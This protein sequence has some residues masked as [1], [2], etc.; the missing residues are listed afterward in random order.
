[1]SSIKQ[2]TFASRI[3][4]SVFIISLISACGGGGGNDGENTPPPANVAPTANA[5]ADQTVDEETTVILSGNGTDSD[6]S[7]TSYAWAQTTGTSVTINGA[8]TATASFDTPTTTTHLTLT[9]QL[10]ITDNDGATASDTID[11]VVNPVNIIPTAD[12]GTDQTV[13]EMTNVTLSG[14]GTDTDGLIDTYMW[15]QSVGTPVTLTNGNTQ[16]AY[17]TAPNVSS[18]E[19]L[20]FELLVTDNEGAEATDTIDITVNPN[21]PPTASAG[22]AQFVT[23][24]NEVTL[25]ASASTDVESSVTYSWLQTD[26]TGINITLDDVNAEQPSF[27]A[28]SLTAAETITFEV[29]VTDAGSLFDT[30]TVN[31]AIAPVITKKINDTGITLCGDLGGSGNYSNSENCSDSIDAEGDVIPLGQDGHYGRDVSANDNGDGN[32][33]FSFTKL[34]ENGEPLPQS[35]SNWSCVKD[36]VTGLIWEVKSND[37]GLQDS[38]NTYT[39]YNS[40]IDT[41]GGD[42]GYSNG[43]VCTDSSCDTEAYVEAINA[44]SLCGANDWY[45]P[46]AEE[47]RSVVDYSLNSFVPLISYPYFINA[48]SN[49][50]W[51]S[52][53]YAN[54]SDT[55]LAVYSTAGD[56]GSVDT[57]T[58]SNAFLIRVVRK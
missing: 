4:L 48:K 24:G 40:D 55:A 21:T 29:T 27:T 34:D 19:V 16:T 9:F 35:A 17:F 22:N 58:K 53:P 20:I 52:T 43:G 54:F 18:N 39:W 11:V 31:I 44:Q 56:V 41:N 2:P 45:L 42:A 25:D 14:S 50:F 10:T 57:H 15:T 26:S 23:S 51:S 46:N 33:G 12:A 32:A 8:E 13:L 5:G 6:G 28:S 49:V 38:T 1:M 47:L 36:N 37:V 7:I 3:I 30:D